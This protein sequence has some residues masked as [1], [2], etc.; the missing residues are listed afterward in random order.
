MQSSQRE[1]TTLRPSHNTG[2]AAS[3]GGA[4]SNE[5]PPTNLVRGMWTAHEYAAFLRV[6]LRTLAE[7]EA[8]G[9]TAVAVVLGPRMKRWLPDECE[10][11]ARRMSRQKLAEPAQLARARIERMK[12]GA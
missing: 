4:R 3:T 5:Q 2:E 11:A 9:L 1:G 10:A 12:A 7:M 8:A 6:G